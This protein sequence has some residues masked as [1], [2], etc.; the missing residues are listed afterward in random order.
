MRTEQKCQDRQGKIRKRGK[1]VVRLGI[2]VFLVLLLASQLHY[3][4]RIQKF[5]L[6]NEEELTE[7][8]K[9]YLAVEQRERRHMFEEWKEENGYSVQLTGLFPEDV[10]AFYMGGFGLVPSSVYY[11]FYYS[12]EDIPVG[13]GEGQLVKAE[14]DSA[15]WSWQGYGDNGGEIRRIKPNWYY[16][17]CWF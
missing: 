16:Y 7:F 11:G 8:A 17:K 14:E 13:T 9:N 4:K 3:E 5:V 12:P 1:R 15:C 2:G 10:V 6:R